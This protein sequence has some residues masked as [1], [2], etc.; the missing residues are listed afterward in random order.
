MKTPRKEQYHHVQIL[1]MT[2]ELTGETNSEDLNEKKK[3][4]NGE[5]EEEERKREKKC[6]KAKE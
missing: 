2:M 3:K 1:P 6:E 5:E 4:K